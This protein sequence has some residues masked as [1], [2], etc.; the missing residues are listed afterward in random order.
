M[1]VTHEVCRFHQPDKIRQRAPA[2][3]KECVRLRGPVPGRTGE[4]SVRHKIPDQIALDAPSCTQ[5]R[6][7]ARGG[8]AHVNEAGFQKAWVLCPR[9]KIHS[10]SLAKLRA[11]CHAPAANGAVEWVSHER[12]SKE[13]WVPSKR[14]STAGESENFRIAF[15]SALLVCL[16]LGAKHSTQKVVER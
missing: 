8:A 15:W 12:K 2:P 16:C 1:Q 4:S 10:F 7:A 11:H 9:R 14:L 3:V 5:R 6:A 13:P